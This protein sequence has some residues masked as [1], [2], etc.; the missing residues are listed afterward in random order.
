MGK[1][2]TYTPFVLPSKE[3]VKDLGRPEKGY[4]TVCSLNFLVVRKARIAVT[5]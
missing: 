5:A 3:A 4:A 2:K 1:K